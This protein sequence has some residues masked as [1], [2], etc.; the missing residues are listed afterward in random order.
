MRPLVALLAFAGLFFAGRAAFA[1]PPSG[2]PIVSPPSSGQSQLALGEELFAG[3][4]VTCHGIAGRGV[5]APSRGAS[6]IHGMGPPLKGVGALAADF[7]L[8]TGYMPL[9]SPTDQPQRS[10]P[11]FSE[12]EIKALVAYVASLG[13]GPAIPRPD[14]ASGSV[15]EGFQQFSEHCAGCHQIVAEG[16]VVTGA[17]APPLNRATATQIAQAVRIGPWVMPKFSQRDISDEQ[18]NSIVRYVLY[19]RNPQD[20]GGWGINHLGPFPEGMVTWLIAIVV[21]VATCM[22][23]GKRM[24]SR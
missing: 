14:P 3:N 18:L 15:A 16:G 24:P 2:P 6:S 9:D 7:Y 8:R 22:V 10:R 4:C 20:E 23:I 13:A 19:T 11:R 12:P 17:K 5:P 1:A 21:L